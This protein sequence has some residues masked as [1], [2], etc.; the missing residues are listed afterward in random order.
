MIDLDHLDSSYLQQ[1]A[2][3]HPDRFV[4][5][6]AQE[7]RIAM[8][9]NA[10]LNEAYR[11]LKSPLSRAVYMQ[12]LCSDIKIDQHTNM[13]IEFLE[14]QIE[15]REEL[16]LTQEVAAL[17]TLKVQV[18]SK[19]E[20]CLELFA[21]A[22]GEDDFIRSQSELDRAMFFDKYLV[23]LQSKLRAIAKEVG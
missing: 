1:Q 19:R 9:C 23:E 4:N 11:T 14:Q 7:Q 2:I 3:T 10:T 20:N 6:S 5:A 17:S 18:E 22:Y 16:E 13:D 15:L 12:S 8:Q 21:R